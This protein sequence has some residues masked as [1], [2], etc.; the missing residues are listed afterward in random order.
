MRKYINH[1][2]QARFVGSMNE[3]FTE[4]STAGVFA[5]A[6]VTTYFSPTREL[7]LTNAGHPP[8]LIWRSKSRQWNFLWESESV[9]AGNIPLGIVELDDYQQLD[10]KLDVGD[11]VLCYTD[12]LIECRGPDGQM[13]GLSGLKQIV[14]ALDPGEPATL[15]ERLLEQIKCQADENLSADDVTVMLFRANGL[16]ATVPLKDKMMAPLRVMKSIVG[17]V[18]GKGPAGV[19]EISIANLGGAMIGFLGRFTGKKKHGRD[20][21]AT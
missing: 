20:A 2:D 10:V 4:L 3:R 12:S 6:V 11:L 9:P 5:T 14:Q 21:H 16:G 19:P 15:I 7:S 18:A 8:P 17:S 13:L 1:I